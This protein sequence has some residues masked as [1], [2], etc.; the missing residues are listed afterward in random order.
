MLALLGR[1][2]QCLA[3]C[4]IV[5]A[6]SW[7]CRSTEPSAGQQLR[8]ANVGTR[9]IQGLVVLFPEDRIEFGDVAAGQTTAYRHVRGVYAYAAYEYRLG[10]VVQHQPVIDWVG[11]KP[12]DGTRFTYSLEL[13]DTPFG[14]RINLARTERD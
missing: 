9:P 13:I 14:T 1:G 10:G 11:E 3:A 8:I 2:W 5:A 6:C 7:T 12:V 4:V